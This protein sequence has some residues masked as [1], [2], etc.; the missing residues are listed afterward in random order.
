M[1]W[2]S[3]RGIAGGNVFLTDGNDTSNQY[4]DENAGRTRV[5][6]QISQDAVQEF[7]VLSSGHSAEYGRASGGIINT[8]T[9]SGSNQTYA[10]AYWFFRNQRLNARDPYASVNPKETRNQFGASLGGKLVQG[11]AVLLLQHGV[12]PARLSAGCLAR[13]PTSVQRQ[14]RVYGL[15]RSFRPQCAAALSYLDRQF[16]VLDRSANS[17]LGFGK[18]DWLPSQRN[19]ISASFNYL[20]W[21]SPDGFQTQAVLNNGEGVGANGNSSVR[22]RYGAAGM[23]VH[24]QRHAD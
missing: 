6:T 7:Q 10:T 17:E 16:Q 19:H 21:I 13:P 5:S 8:V 22:T 18:I 2:C 23:D 4:F 15:L 12:P 14:R 1:G 11:Q 3:F 20:R 9:R 24:S